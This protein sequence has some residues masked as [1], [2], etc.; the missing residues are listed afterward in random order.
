MTCRSR[1]ITCLLCAASW[2]AQPQQIPN[3]QGDNRVSDD[4]TPPPEWLILPHKNTPLDS[5]LAVHGL[6]ESNPKFR[7]FGTV[8]VHADKS[9]TDNHK[10]KAL[11]SALQSEAGLI[12]VQRN[13]RVHRRGWPNDPLVTSQW[14]HDHPNGKDLASDSAWAIST[15]GVNPLGFKPVIAIIEGFDPDHP[16]LAPNTRYNPGEID[17]NLVD[18]D[19]N[20][21]VDDYAGWNPWT[22]TDVVS[23]DDHGTAVAGMAGA[24][25]NN[26]FQGAGIAPDAELLRIDIGP[27]TE[28]DVV[29]AYAYAR[30]LR[31][32]FNT[33]GGTAGAFIVATNASWGIDYADPADHPLWCAVYD[34]LLEV[35]IL[36]CAATA[37][38][39]INVDLVGDMPTACTSEGLISV[40]AIDST[41]AR[42]Q[43]GYGANSIDLG[44]PGK[45]LLLPTGWDTPAD[46]SMAIWSGTSF[47]SPAAAGVIGLL[48]GAPCP[49]F[50]GQALSQP[51]AAALRVREAL[52]SGTVPEAELLGA[53][54]TGGRL[55]SLNALM[56]LMDNC[57]DVDT[58]GCTLPGACNFNWFATWDDGTCDSTSCHGCTDSEACNFNPSAVHNDG[59]C[60]YAETGLD[61]N[62]GC[63]FQFQH[64]VNLGAGESHVRHFSGIGN[65]GTV[66]LAM[67]FNSGGGAWASDQVLII[68]SPNGTLRQLGGFAPL[69]EAALPAGMNPEA[70]TWNGDMPFVWGTNAP[71]NFSAEYTM[72]GM[73]GHG[74][75][76]CHFINGFGGSG[77]SLSNWTLTWPGWC[78]HG[79]TNCPEDVDGDAFVSISDLL[80]TLSSWGCQG[81]CTGDVDASGQVGVSDLVLLLSLFGEGC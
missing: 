31:R 39:S 29:A 20:G 1:L 13:H 7:P 60:G 74:I 14:H 55:H 71:G 12:A 72:A 15:G 28:A 67:V 54:A 11:E 36:N 59:S 44:A 53:T 58:V 78:T 42:S 38:L 43:A 46:S 57:T 49:E 2:G 16:D 75:W 48:Y 66:Q 24:A 23:Q 27:L 81:T 22:G 79:R 10:L 64:S 41:G 65:G 21:Y 70:L 56:A 3:L 33:S 62:G 19:G 76:R 34:S 47:S 45:H 25:R 32:Q 18:D 50:A 63:L 5:L 17:N 30:D 68:E 35:G 6:K 52:L 8:R 4:A 37:N 61:C 69:P 80:W 40:T 77:S 73:S 26:G 9:A 51:S